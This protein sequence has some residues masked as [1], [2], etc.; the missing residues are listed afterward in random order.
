MPLPSLPPAFQLVALDRDVDAF[1]RA[2]RAAPRGLDDGTVYWT[3]RDDRLRL[4]VAFEPELRRAEAI[5]AVYVL[6]VAAANA[7][8]ALL[9]A[10]LPLALA[11]PGGIVLDGARVGR[12]CVALGPAAEPEAV[13]PWLVLGLGIEVGPS[14]REPGET[15]DLTTLADSGAED[16]T[17]VALAESVG[18]HF[19]SWLHRWAEDG[20]EPVRAAW[21]RRCFRLGEKATLDLAGDLRDGRI[22]GLDP[23]GRFRIGTAALPLEAALDELG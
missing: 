10:G 1:E 16:V 17:S 7:L 2:C 23:E 21:N 15:P 4:A 3:D 8:A 9:P 19:L 5:E 22:A 12:V 18:R 13:P 14:V 6:A 20:L 11:W